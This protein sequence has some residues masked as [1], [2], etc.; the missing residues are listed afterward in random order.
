[1]S[2]FE[3]YQELEKFLNK[4]T[5]VGPA[6]D[7]IK[8]KRNFIFSKFNL[9]IDTFKNLN[10]YKSK[11]NKNFNLIVSVDDQISFYEQLYIQL[12]DQNFFE[13]LKKVDH[14][15][16]FKNNKFYKFEKNKFFKFIKI[17]N[18]LT[19]PL[20]ILSIFLYILLIFP[21]KYKG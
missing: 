15:L 6:H 14:C 10:F 12:N 21:A 16:I 9:T 7:K 20:R 11:L 1:V 8:I 2:T 3:K 17:F 18:F 4:A 19:L 5:Y 13:S